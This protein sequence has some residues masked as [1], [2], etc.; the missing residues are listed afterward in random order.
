MQRLLVGACGRACDMHAG[1]C[2]LPGLQGI[3]YTP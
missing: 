2:Y 3:P 1:R